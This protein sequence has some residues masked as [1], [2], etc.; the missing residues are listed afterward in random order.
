MELISKFNIDQTAFIISQ[1]KIK[2]VRVDKIMFK[3]EKNY[4][5]GGRIEHAIRYTV[6]S[7]IDLSESELYAT[8]A[9]AL[10]TLLPKED[11][12]RVVKQVSGDLM[13]KSTYNPED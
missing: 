5:Y 10:A 2:P 6:D 12:E 13:D 3:A 4:G 1:G 9:E 7:S 8:Q 11:F